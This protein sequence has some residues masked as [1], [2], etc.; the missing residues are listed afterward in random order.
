MK[1]ILGFIFAILALTVAML[2][3]ASFSLSNYHIFIAEVLIGE[4][5][6]KAYLV[7][8][9]VFVLIAIVL[10]FIWSWIKLIPGKKEK[11]STLKIIEKVIFHLLLATFIFAAYMGVV[12]FI[13]INKATKG[14][15]KADISRIVDFSYSYAADTDK[16]RMK[17]SEHQRDYQQKSKADFYIEA[18]KNIE[19]KTPLMISIIDNLYYDGTYE[20]I[21][22]RDSDGRTALMYAI[23]LSAGSETVKMLLENGAD[24]KMHD[25]KNITV[26]MYAASYADSPEIIE[27]LINKGADV[28]EKTSGQ[29]KPLHFAAQYNEN[30]DIIKALI[31]HGA[32]PEDMAYY[33]IRGEYKSPLM[34][35]VEYNN[36]GEVIAYLAD[37]VMDINAF[38]YGVNILDLAVQYGTIDT[39]QIILDAGADVNKGAF[40]QGYS[41]LAIAAMDNEDINVAKMLIDAGADINISNK[42]YI[43]SSALMTAA[44]GGTPEMVELLLKKEA[45]INVKNL[46]GMGAIEVAAANPDAAEVISLLKKHGVESGRVQGVYFPPIVLA[47][48]INP[49][50]EQL[51]L[52]IQQGEDINALNSE[53]MSA[54]S[55]ACRYNVNSEVAKVFLK[56]GLKVNGIDIA[57]GKKHIDYAGANRNIEMLETLLNYYPE[58]NTESLRRILFEAV[59]SGNAAAIRFLKSYGLDI[60]VQNERDGKTALMYAAQISSNP[61][62]IN[63]LLESGAETYIKD[64]EGKTAAYYLKKNK[65]LSKF[66]IKLD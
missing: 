14:F 55:A 19:D 5:H 47:A 20:N 58:Q 59:E 2:I 38:V 61:R 40:K 52:L 66:N 25:N 57:T 33:S 16:R 43:F 29:K 26:L 22:F 42:N 30:A 6:Y 18:R 17:I 32:N 9:I 28:D 34:V 49:D 27:M 8:A 7:T 50:P 36:S 63:A 3:Y 46:Y 10:L 53:G 31:K 24:A 65:K 62:V 54:F 12:F 23:G 1:K 11:T 48:M 4:G 35:A 45:N 15:K 51:E 64:N 13:D 44:W 37:S 56:H 21:N 60:N 41:A 39:V